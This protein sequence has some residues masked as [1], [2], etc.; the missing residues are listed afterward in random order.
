MKLYNKHPLNTRTSPSPRHFSA[1]FSGLSALIFFLVSSLSLFLNS[2]SF[3]AAAFFSRFFLP[4]G[5][6]VNHCLITL[7]LTILGLSSFLPLSLLSFFS[8][9]SRIDSMRHLLLV[10]WAVLEFVS[11]GSSVMS[12]VL[13]GLLLFLSGLLG[14]EFFAVYSGRSS[15][16]FRMFSLTKKNA[17]S[18]QR[19]LS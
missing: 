1:S 13:S 6:I 10:L 14:L 17:W 16:S 5:S 3:L 11:L 4:K 19:L 18:E 12:T 8:I 9:L 7:P 15:M 2:S